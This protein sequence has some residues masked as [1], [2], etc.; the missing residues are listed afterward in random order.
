MRLYMV[1]SPTLKAPQL[2]SSCKRSSI[3]HNARLRTR[4]L[5]QSRSLLLLLYALGRLLYLSIA[6]A[7]HSGATQ[8]AK[9]ATRKEVAFDRLFLNSSIPDHSC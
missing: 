4:L 9:S 8:G 2:R 1:G 3:R 6:S 5:A 7:P